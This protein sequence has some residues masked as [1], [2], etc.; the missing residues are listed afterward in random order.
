M[1]VQCSSNLRQFG[2]ADQMYM[3]TYK[4]WH[5]PAFWG[6][7]YRFNRTWPCFYE[8]RKTLAMPMPGNANANAY[9]DPKWRCPLVDVRGTNDQVYDAATNTSFWPMNYSYGM[10]VEGIDEAQ[11]IATFPETADV[12]SCPW[13]RQPVSAPTDPASLHA[14]RRAQVK[15]PTEKLFIADAIW[16]IINEQG[17]GITP[18]WQGGPSNYDVIGESPN[19]PNS[20]RTIAWRHKGLCNVLFFD[21]HVE[22]VRKDQIFNKDQNVANHRLWKV[23]Q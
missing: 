8:F 17:S 16:I 2:I 5:L 14:F 10:N 23:M 9:V 12:V 15:R 3:N 19:K 1:Q 18:G 20:N 22:A 4:D 11:Y 6:Q 21:G 7:N 13:I